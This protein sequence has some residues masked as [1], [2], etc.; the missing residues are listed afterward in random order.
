MGLPIVST[1]II[2]LSIVFSV[3]A[4][5]AVA[6]RFRARAVQCAGYSLDDLMII[7]GLVSWKLCGLLTMLT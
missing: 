3:L 5:I 7:P 6:L 1:D 4:I 2:I